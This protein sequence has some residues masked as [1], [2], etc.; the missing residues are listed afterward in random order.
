M[1]K[2]QDPAFI[3][4]VYWH[5]TALLTDIHLNGINKGCELSVLGVIVHGPLW[6]VRTIL[7]E[8]REP[9]LLWM[10]MISEG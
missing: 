2:K 7:S 5:N 6:S 8:Y 1:Q 9:E 10:Q 3:Q 4:G